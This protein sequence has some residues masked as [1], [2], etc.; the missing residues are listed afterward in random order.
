MRARLLEDLHR[1]VD[2]GRDAPVDREHVVVAR[3]GD[4]HALDRAAH[5]AGE[6]G[7]VVERERV[8]RVVAGDRGEHERGILHRARQ[9]PFEQERVRPAEGVRARDER[10]AAERLLEPVDAAPRS[11]DANRAAAVGALGEGQ[12]AIGHRGRAAARGPAGVPAGVKRVAA[13][14]EERVVA[15]APEAHD[16]AVA[17]ADQDR[18]RLLGTLRERAVGV[19]LEV[20]Q[21]RD[22]AERRRPPRL[23]VEQVLDRR[24][25]PVQQP[26]GLAAHQRRLGLTRR[27]AR[28][29]E[30]QDKP[31]RSG[32][33]CAPRCAR[34]SL[35]ALR[36]ATPRAV[37][38]APPIRRP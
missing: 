35:P 4:A 24:R 13:R 9:R 17:L 25:H 26:D 21:R 11:R 16:R 1:F 3:I 8:A 29:V 19:E 37:G 7:R 2:H 33:G 34:S 38:S 32:S 31:A 5:R 12:Q 27:G 20:P 28:V 36:P 15:H 6:V 30:A 22:A 23:E 18:A 10:H 14:P